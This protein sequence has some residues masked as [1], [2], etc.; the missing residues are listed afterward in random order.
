MKPVFTTHVPLI[1]ASA[2][3]R[4]K[5]FLED[6]GLVFSVEAAHIDERVQNGEDPASFVRRIAS[7]KAASIAAVHPASWVLAADTVVVI[8]R[9]ILGKPASGEEAVAMLQRLAGRQHEVWTGFCLRQGQ[10]THLVE[11]QIRTAVSFRSFSVEVCR[12]YVQSGES[13]DKAGAYGIQGLGGFLVAGI[14]GSY[15]N[16]VGLPLAEVIEE[17]E[18][19]GIIS[20][21]VV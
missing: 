14:E 11:R 10:T 15:S 1:L 4:R 17:M 21:I 19:I 7:E 8:D 6:L 9:T 18:K 20:P 2:S 13:L 5:T 3:P 16:V 12:A